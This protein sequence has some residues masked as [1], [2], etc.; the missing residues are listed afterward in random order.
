MSPGPWITNRYQF[1]IQKVPISINWSF[2]MIGL[3][4]SEDDSIL[5]NKKE[6]VLVGK[7]KGRSQI[8]G[9]QL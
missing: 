3:N 6:H 1:R 4:L 7:S 2:Y 8:H 9:T 5:I